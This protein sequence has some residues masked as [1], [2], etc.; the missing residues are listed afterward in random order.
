M[1]VSKV[2]MRLFSS[3]PRQNMA[4]EMPKNKETSLRCL[5]L[6]PGVYVL[7]SVCV[8]RSVVC[9]PIT[10]EGGVGEGQQSFGFKV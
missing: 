8:Q 6:F 2:A 4:R 1:Y 9:L 3:F 10:G 7:S 5:I